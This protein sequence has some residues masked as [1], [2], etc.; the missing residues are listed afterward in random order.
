MDDSQPAE[1]AGAGAKAAPQSAIPAAGLAL[2]GLLT[3]FWGINF[4]FMKL[5]LDAFD[6]WLFRVVCLGAGAAGLFAIA[7][8][9]GQRLAVPRRDRRMLGW[10]ALLSITGWHV[11][12]A[13]GI[14]MMPAGR[15]AILA[16]TMPLWA[17]VMAWAFL[18]ERLTPLRLAGLALGLAGMAFLI[19]DEFA[20]LGAAPWG[21]LLI[22]AAAVFWAGGTVALK[23]HRWSMGT[24]ALTGWQMALGGMPVVLGAV[25]LGRLPDPAQVTAV[26]W[27]A[28]AYSATIPMVLCHWAWNRLVGL[29]PA[30][31]AVV[32]TLMIPVVGVLSSMPLTG[33]TVGYREILAL[34]LVVA[35][36]AIVLVLP[37]WLKPAA[38]GAAP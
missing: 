19:G 8:A 38:S 3:V 24:A 16:Y 12:V 20:K 27:I 10:T 17:T 6:P 22:V 37:A 35:A 5:A 30:S 23:S 32:G 26:Q 9:G 21:A 28:L 11:C 18:G 1:P 13:F 33:E 25:L 34:V 29:V 36:L 31:V 15:A 4:P 14:A 2:L 7:R